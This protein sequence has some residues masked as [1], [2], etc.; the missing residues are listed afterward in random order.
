MKLDQEAL[1]NAAG[2]QFSDSQIDDLK[3]AAEYYYYWS[4]EHE[5]HADGSAYSTKAVYERL[6]KIADLSAQL[7]KELSRN[8]VDGRVIHWYLDVS[9]VL[10]GI[11]VMRECALEKIGEVSRISKEER[12]QSSPATIRARRFLTSW[13]HRCWHEAGGQGVGDKINTWDDREDNGPVIRLVQEL[14]RQAGLPELLSA[15]TIQRD[16]RRQPK[17][18]LVSSATEVFTRPPKLLR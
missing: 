6:H 8:D 1:N 9:D 7:D 12:G 14:A 13:A 3:I 16:L 11:R 10:S 4:T 5:E 17:P 18:Y 2:V 15:K